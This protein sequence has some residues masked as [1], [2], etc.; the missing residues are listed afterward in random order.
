MNIL[1]C[2]GCDKP[3]PTQPPRTPEWTSVIITVDSNSA[4]LDL[5]QGCV[6]SHASA[7]VVLARKR[8]A[9]ILKR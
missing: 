2:D 5:C 1:H 7:L 6:E 3:F 4:A 9:R 8:I